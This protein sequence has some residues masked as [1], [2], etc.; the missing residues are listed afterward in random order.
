MSKIY[1]HGENTSSKEYSAWSSLR[2]RC[3][4]KTRDS[5]KKYYKH[6]GIKVCDRW[7]DYLNFLEDMGRAPS[8]KHSLDRIDN[9]KGYSKENCRWATHL[10]Q[11]QNTDANNYVSYNGKTQSVA[12]WARELKIAY[13]VLSDRVGKLGWSVEKA[14]MTPV[15]KS[16]AT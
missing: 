3:G 6:K 4:G 12:A 5:D 2:R 1:K 16:R 14:F 11:M 9:S 7:R 10:Q 8:D 15:R 13:W